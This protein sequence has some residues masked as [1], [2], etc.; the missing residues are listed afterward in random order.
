V[1]LIS[2]GIIGE[3]IRRLSDNVRSRP[4]Y[5]IN[6]TDKPPPEYSVLNLPAGFLLSIFQN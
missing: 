5:I 1:Q 2:T 3:Y 6:E 4:L